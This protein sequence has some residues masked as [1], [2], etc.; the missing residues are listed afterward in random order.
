MNPKQA[1]SCNPRRCGCTVTTAKQCRTCKKQLSATL[2]QHALVSIYIVNAVDI[3]NKPS[4][5][6]STAIGSCVALSYNKVKASV[7]QSPHVAFLL[8]F[9]VEPSRREVPPF[10]TTLVHS[11]PAAELPHFTS[12]R[13][14]SGL[15]LQQ[16]I[17][18]RRRGCGRAHRSNWRFALKW[19]QQIPLVGVRSAK[20]HVQ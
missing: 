14:A 5:V 10:R 9:P 13:L 18:P 6:L 11:P 20:D 12:P 2:P 3:V 19:V 4:N 1:N 16:S 17:K 8:N 7:F 15:F